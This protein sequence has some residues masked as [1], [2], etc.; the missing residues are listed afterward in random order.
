MW[1]EYLEEHKADAAPESAFNLDVDHEFKVGMK[2]EAVHPG[3]KHQVRACLLL[4]LLKRTDKV[5]KIQILLSITIY[6]LHCS[7]EER[8]S[9]TTLFRNSI[10]EYWIC[11][12]Q[13]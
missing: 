6:F 9:I 2:L 13:I 4:F 1:R 5:Y 3:R 8:P 10:I 7:S 12:M 11:M